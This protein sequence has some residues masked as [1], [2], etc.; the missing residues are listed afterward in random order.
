M[1]V[2]ALAGLAFLGYGEQYGRG[3][4]GD[5]LVQAVRYL[6]QK[7]TTGRAGYIDDESSR[8]HG[9]AYAV[10]FLTQVLGS[11]PDPRSEAK[12]R[13]VVYEGIEFIAHAQ[14][15]DGGWGYEANE[16]FDEASITVCCLQALRAAK[17]AGI[18]LKP[19]TSASPGSSNDRMRA[20]VDAAVGYLVRCCLDDGSFKYS[21]KRGIDRSSYELTAA[22][23]STLDAAGKYSADEHK[24]G[25]GFLL[26]TLSRYG[27]TPLKAS[28][29]YPYYGNFY[30]G[31]VYHQLGGEVWRGWQPDATRELLAMQKSDGSWESK[32]GSEYATAMAILILEIPMAY[33]PI[34]ER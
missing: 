9:H 30:A 19:L 1:A 16:K 29:N 33:L 4:Y 5:V 14:T 2:T 11:I 34:Y 24:R 3:R 13:E 28:V 7:S 15:L 26:R 8:M 18:A 17:D 22:A 6:A 32:F 20:V 12:V 10:L 21:L 23:V 27:R 31:Q 25:V